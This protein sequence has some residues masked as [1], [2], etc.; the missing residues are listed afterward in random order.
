MT[1]VIATFNAGSSSLKWAFYDAASLK[2]LDK[3]VINGSD[4]TG[5]AGTILDQVQQKKMHLVAVGHR[6]VH[7][8]DH[9]KPAVMTSQLRD[10]LEAFIPLAPLHQPHNLKLIDE[11][12]RLYPHLPQIACFDTSFHSTQ[13]K[14]AT[15]F[16]L[17]RALYDEGIRRYG[18]HGVSY[19]HIASVLPQVAGKEARGRV[20]VAHLGS[21]SSLCAMKDLKS[22]AT[23]MGFSTLDGLM[24]GT[25]CGTMDPG[26]ILYLLREKKMT[27]NQVEDMLY[28]QSGLK[29]VSGISADIRELLLCPQKE[30]LDAVRLYCYLTAQ[31]IAALAAAIGG[32]DLLVFTGGVGEHQSEIREC[33]C[34]HLAWMRVA[35]DIVKNSVGDGALEC[36]GSDIGIRMIPTNEELVIARHCQTFV[37]ARGVDQTGG[38]LHEQLGRPK[39]YLVMPDIKKLAT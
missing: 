9:A 12:T 21:G 10:Q 31:H 29:G 32:L 20:I 1:D 3:Q 26:V 13:S 6:V 2:Q 22:Q 14:L 35:I 33:I 16:P 36:D 24:M 18:F 19:E 5:A 17:P 8:K 15:M 4:Q 25:R 34:M 39:A 7:G 23:S 37:N 27:L 30:A 38:T 28:H 11:V